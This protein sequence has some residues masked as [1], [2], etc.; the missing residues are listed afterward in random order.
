V[1]RRLKHPHQKIKALALPEIRITNLILRHRI[2]V[3]ILLEDSIA[4]LPLSQ[5]I[6]LEIQ[7]IQQALP[8]RLLRRE[9]IKARAAAPAMVLSRND[10]PYRKGF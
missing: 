9:A 5:G 3:L 10:K 7:I 8:P 6:K 1:A 2:K 4:S